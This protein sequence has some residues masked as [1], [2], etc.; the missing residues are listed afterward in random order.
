MRLAFFSITVNLTPYSLVDG[1]ERYGGTRRLQPS[2]ILWRWRQYVLAERWY[3]V[4]NFTESHELLSCA[5]LLVSS[6]ST[7]CCRFQAYE[8]PIILLAVH[9]HL[10]FLLSTL[11]AQDFLLFSPPREKNFALRNVFLLF[12][13]PLPSLQ[14]PLFSFPYCARGGSMVGWL[15]RADWRSEQGINR[16]EL[17]RGGLIGNQSGWVERGRTCRWLWTCSFLEPIH[18]K[19]VRGFYC[20]AEERLKSIASNWN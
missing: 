2:H 18:Y 13:A 5:R 16:R 11:P 6:K 7:I 12:L 19:L 10:I 20:T 1:C 4:R 17:E 9:S 15:Q 8:S 14:L 3:H